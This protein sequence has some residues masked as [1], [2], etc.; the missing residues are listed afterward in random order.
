[1]DNQ[2]SAMKDDVGKAVRFL[3]RIVKT[4]NEKVDK[5]R[6]DKF[7]EHLIAILCER[8]TGHW[9]PEKPMKGQAYRCIRINRNSPVDESLL[10]A[11]KESGLEYSE[12]KLPREFTLW[13][14]PGDVCCRLSESSQHFTVKEEEESSSSS[15]KTTPEMETS[16]YHSESPTSEFSSED[17][18]KAKLLANSGAVSKYQ[19]GQNNNKQV[20]QYF[21]TPSPLWVPGHQNVVSYLPAYQPV[22]FYYPGF[23]LKKPVPRKPNPNLV[24]RLTQRASKP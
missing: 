2:Q 6:V 17:E 24:K 15:G 14:D 13:I 22:A 23:N 4:R 1:M 12:L 16:D 18:G 20:T 3:C 9:Y 21:Y 7:G 5:E 8:Y 10:K 19:P 11:C